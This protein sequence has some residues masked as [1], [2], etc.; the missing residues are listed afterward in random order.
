MR[1]ATAI[2]LVLLVGI[3][4]ESPAQAAPLQ[5]EPPVTLHDAW[6]REVLDLDT[7]GAAAAYTI[8]GA[9]PTNLERWVATARLA[10]LQRLGISMPA[11]VPTNDAPLALRDSFSRMVEPL[12][13]A[14]LLQRATDPAQLLRT[15][16]TDAGRLPPMR[17]VTTEA[18]RWC[19]TQ[20]PGVRDRLPRVPTNTV[21]R[22]N[23]NRFTA[24]EILRA[25]LSGQPTRAQNLRMIYFANWQPP[26]WSGEA[27]AGLEQVRVQ[28][29]ATMHDPEYSV[30]RRLLS[31][32]RDAFNE[33]ANTDPVAAMAL[34]ARLPLYAERL[35]GLPGSAGTA[36]PR[37]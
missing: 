31:E 1:W 12:P 4:A 6:L 34:I 2:G 3:A 14:E 5:P 30:Q 11:K 18:E 35:L 10:E 17:P 37:R 33:R 32:L 21:S 16:G 15:V 8:V 26:R 23:Y 28:L 36:S 29:E 13:V 22:A 20:V 9:D 27:K 7:K 25:E 19:L 24:A